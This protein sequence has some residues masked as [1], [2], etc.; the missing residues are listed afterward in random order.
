MHV[1]SNIRQFSCYLKDKQLSCLTCISPLPSYIKF[2]K[3]KYFK[4]IFRR[5]KTY[6]AFQHLS[7]RGNQQFK[8]NFPWY[9]WINSTHSSDHF[10]EANCSTLKACK[11]VTFNAR[12]LQ[13]WNRVFNKVNFKTKQKQISLHRYLNK[14]K[15][16]LE[17]IMEKRML[18]S[19]QRKY[20]P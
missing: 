10:W 5:N 4:A 20:V 12:C 14:L 16:K 3:F 2:S 18:D 15:S 8:A 11:I 6:S 17:I 9:F 1:E 13:L 19:C 7:N